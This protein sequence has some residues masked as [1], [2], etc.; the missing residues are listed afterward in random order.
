MADTTPTPVD[1]TLTP[2][3][4]AERQSAA[5]IVDVRT[6]EEREAGYIADSLHIPVDEI[7]ARAGELDKGRTVIFYCRGGDRS[8]SVA[9]A[10]RASGWEAYS[11][12]GGLVAWAEQGHP[13]EPEGGTVGQRTGLPPR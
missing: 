8:A 2:E 13:L 4:V 1:E 6:D 5:Q 7:T 10:F 9:E 3:G 11:L 12:E